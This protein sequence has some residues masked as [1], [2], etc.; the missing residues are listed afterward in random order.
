MYECIAQ[1]WHKDISN[2]AGVNVTISVI[3]IRQQCGAAEAQQETEEKNKRKTKRS[4]VRFPAWSQFCKELRK[5][6]FPKLG[7]R[8]K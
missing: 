2:Y 1:N 6:G 8:S 3:H 7:Q 4:Q 5:L